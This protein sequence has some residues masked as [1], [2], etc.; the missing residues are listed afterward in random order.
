MIETSAVI[1]VV[2]DVKVPKTEALEVLAHA[3]SARRSGTLSDPQLVRENGVRVSIEVPKFGEDLPLTLDIHWAAQSGEVTIEAFAI[4]SQI[5]KVLGWNCEV[6]E[7][8]PV[9]DSARG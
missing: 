7:T 9:P 5:T 4:V 3:L 6:L 8:N 1:S 2:C